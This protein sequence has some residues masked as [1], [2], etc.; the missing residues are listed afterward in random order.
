M[1]VENNGQQLVKTREQVK[2]EKKEKKKQEKLETGEQTGWVRVRLFPI[3]LRLIV[4]AVLIV[5]FI[6][7]GAIFGYSVLGGGKVS[8]V[9]DKSTWVHIVDIVKKEE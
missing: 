4:I 1:Q 9:F 6:V 2:L 5:V 8:E 3:W 7:I